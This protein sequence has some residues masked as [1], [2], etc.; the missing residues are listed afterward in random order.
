M[1]T[2]GELAA[3]RPSASSSFVPGVHAARAVAVLLVL[4]AHVVG[5][6]TNQEDF[7]Y[8]PWQAY[9]KVVIDPLRI[10]HQAGGHMGLLL[11]FV[12]SGY[13][14]SQA[15]EADGRL[16]FAVKR[17]AR[18][19]P[20]MV[21]AVAATLA[22]A[23]FDR[24]LGVPMPNE[25]VADRAFSWHSVTEAVGLGP[26][27]GGIGVLFVLWTLNVEYQWYVLLGIA[28]GPAVR[29]PLASTIA[30]MVT[31]AMLV[32]F[33]PASLGPLAF[34][35]DHLT[36]VLVIL[37]GRWIYIADRRAVA[38]PVAAVGVAASI[39]LYVGLR[40]PLDGAELLT[41]EHPRIAAVLWATL[42]FVLLLRAVRG[43]LWKPVRFV[44]DVSYGIYL[45]H[46]PIMWLVL[47]VISPGGRLFTLGIATTV[48]LVLLAAWASYRFV[49][50]PIRRDVRRRLS[51]GPHRPTA[52]VPPMEAVSGG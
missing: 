49:E 51:R 50:T 45:F 48:G 7:R 25:F 36:Y 26:T 47:P 31:V 44:G 14:V 15:A 39:L 32:R 13:I 6:W 42:I 22:V 34:S 43:P 17:A 21:I 40:L 10:D 5:L 18:L 29:R 35:I 3:A 9:L 19:L 24:A 8:L 46:I 27:F 11:F 30:M 38:W 4:A 41:G 33:A 23:A 12:V 20:P 16:A 28:L 1:T 2:T 37:V 52:D